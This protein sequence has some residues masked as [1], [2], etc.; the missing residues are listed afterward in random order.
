MENDPLIGQQ[1]GAYYIQGTLGEGGSGRVVA[2]RMRTGHTVAVKVVHKA[3]AYRNPFG[4]ENLK[5][6]KFNW[7]RVTH[8]RRPFLVH[9]LMSFDDP[10]NIYFVMVSILSSRATHA[11]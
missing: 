6:E 11:D 7:E 9:L 8:E 1:L 3:K 5:D 4:R 2:A 10:E